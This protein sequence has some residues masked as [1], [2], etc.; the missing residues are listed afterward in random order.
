[1]I[2]RAVLF[3]FPVALFGQVATAPPFE[4]ASVRRNDSPDPR[5]DFRANPNGITIS[6]YRLQFLIPYAYDIAVYQIAGAPAWLS[7]NKYDIVA[8]APSG[9]SDQQLRLMM[10]QLLEERFKLR[11]HRERKEL[12]AYAL[13]LSKDGPKLQVEKRE[14]R[15]GD[16]RVGAGRG[17]AVG[18][19]VS[20]SAFA[21]TL[22]LFVDRPVFDETAIDGLFNF[23]L[24][25]VP[26]ETE[27]QVGP[28]LAGA[29]VP[30]EQP[31]GPSLFAALEEQLG[32]RLVSQRKSVEMFVIE[33][34]EEV[35]TEN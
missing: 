3:F 11:Y 14:Q 8:R 24:R 1:M 30:S 12:S 15:E 6:N 20:S 29:A 4:A 13:V 17:T 31:A 19:M 10:R 21:Q 7:S 27:R 28:P 23:E 9:T 26:D 32:L 5:S 25:W 34:I 35:P 2:R 16:G 33:H 22:S 18:H